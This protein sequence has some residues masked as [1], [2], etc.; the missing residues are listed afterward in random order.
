VSGKT[1]V[2]IGEAEQ[3]AMLRELRR[4]RYGYLLALHVLLLCAAGHSPTLIS[5]VLFCSRASVYRIVE[6]W[7]G[8]TPGFSF[9]D[10]GEVSRPMRARSLTPRLRR[11]LLSILKKSPRVLG[12]CRTRWSCA[13]VALEMKARL[14]VEVS[15][16]TVRRWIREIGWVWK[17]A[18]LVAR[19]D[20]AERVAKLARIRAV[21]EGLGKSERVFFADELDIHLLAKVGYEW[22][23]K[24]TQVEVMTPGKNEKQYLAGALDWATGLVTSVIGARKTNDLFLDLLEAIDAQLTLR[25]VRRIY[26]VVDNY[27]IHKA[28]P[29]TAWLER[30][31]RFELLFLPTYCPRANP[32]ERVF[33]DIHDRC[34]RNHQR[35]RLNDLVRDVQDY[36]ARNGPWQYRLSEIYHAPEVTAEVEKRHLSQAA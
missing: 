8:G 10:A 32:I 21:I 28:A 9:D 30:H 1:I 36:L 18:K 27:G 19:D 4:S 15:G 6:A 25:K 26:V 29:V 2:E 20:D 16:E 34:T 11:S 33:G 7:R 17:R 22:M 13:A 12:W 24:G 3:A 23:P 35:T 14:G 31:P 5:R